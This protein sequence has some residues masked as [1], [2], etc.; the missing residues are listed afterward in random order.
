L[1]AADSS[2]LPRGEVA[3]HDHRYLAQYATVRLQRLESRIDRLNGAVDGLADVRDHQS[4]RR[5]LHRQSHSALEKGLRLA[6]ERVGFE[7]P[8]QQID[9]DMLGAALS[10]DGID[11]AVRFDY[12]CRLAGAGAE[13]DPAAAPPDGLRGLDKA[14]LAVGGVEDEVDAPATGQLCDFD[15]DVVALI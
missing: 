7:E 3:I 15:T 5:P 13:H 1:T 4:L 14:L 12:A 6:V 2:V 11:W 10:Q 8:A 9:V